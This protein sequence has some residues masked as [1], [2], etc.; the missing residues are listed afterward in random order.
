[1]AIAL[2]Q[3]NQGEAPSVLVASV[4]AGGGAFRNRD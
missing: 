4:G 2:G 3:L 1:M